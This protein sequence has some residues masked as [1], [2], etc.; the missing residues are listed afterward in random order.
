M[1]APKKAQA[2]KWKIPWGKYSP[3]T[4]FFIPLPPEK[5]VQVN[6]LV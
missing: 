2:P 3:V 5:W 6:I 4:L 1:S